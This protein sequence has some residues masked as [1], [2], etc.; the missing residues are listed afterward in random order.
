MKKV[1][2]VIWNVLKYIVCTLA[3]GIS[4]IFMFSQNKKENEIIESKAEN[5][6]EKKK[7]EIQ[8]TD[9]ADLI[10]DS[11]NKEYI[12]ST[13][14]REQDEFRKRIRDRLNKDV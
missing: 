13:I 11:D 2:S 7:D 6:K 10:N 3:F 8:K 1:L 9:A 12:H 4:V 5:E 14:T